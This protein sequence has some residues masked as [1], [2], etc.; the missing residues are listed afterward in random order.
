MDD[1]QIIP[2]P[3]FPE[4]SIDATPG[5]E[6]ISAAE[7]P[8]AIVPQIEAGEE[9][10]AAAAGHEEAESR[11]RSFRQNLYLLLALALAAFILTSW[12]L[13]RVD[14]PFGIFATGPQEV[15]R[16]QLRALDRGELK[17]A[18]E[19]F[20]ARYRSQVPFGAWHELCVAHWQ[21]FHADVV[22][23]DQPE[24]SG[25]SILLEIYLRGADATNYRARF[26]VVRANGRWWIDDVHWTEEPSGREFWRA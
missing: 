8:A 3:A 26:T 10:R 24:P 17:P 13:V 11:R 16:A 15:V 20:S 22:R 6:P 5:H 21:M 25:A 7:P 18:Y 4:K 23:A 9:W 2:D 14:S 12:I 1:P 19:M